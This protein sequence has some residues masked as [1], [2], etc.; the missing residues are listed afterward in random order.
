M[1]ILNVFGVRTNALYID[2]MNQYR[3]LCTFPG[4]PRNG[5][6]VLVEYMLSILYCI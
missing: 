4:N 2:N 1:Y 6:G 5:V 3:T